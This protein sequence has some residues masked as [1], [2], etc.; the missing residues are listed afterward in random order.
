MR[1]LRN[2]HSKAVLSFDELSHCVSIRTQGRA[3]IFHQQVCT[4]CN[5]N[6][7]SHTLSLKI[8]MLQLRLI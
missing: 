7:T 6:F 2:S 5:N 3:K 4:Y 8:K 1:Y